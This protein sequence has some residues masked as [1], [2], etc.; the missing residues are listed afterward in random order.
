M[1]TAAWFFLAIN[2]LKLPFSAGLGLVDG[3][4]LAINAALAPVVVGGLFAGRA[5]TARIPQRWFD[6]LVLAFAVAASVKFLLSPAR[7]P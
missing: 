4:S 3:G 7:L 5:L 6:H 1:G 2:V